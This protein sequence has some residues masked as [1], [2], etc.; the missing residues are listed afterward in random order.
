MTRGR[1]SIGVF[2]TD[3]ALVVQSWDSW[4]AEATGIPETAACGQP[5]AQLYPELARRGL[6][7]RLKRVADGMGVDVLAPAFHKYLLPCV[8]RDRMSRFERM[9]QHVTLAPLRNRDRVDGVVVTIED[10]TERFDRDRR[11]AADL[12]SH[13]EAIR[14]R[15]VKALAATGDAPALLSNALSDE[16]WRVRRVAAEGMADGGGRDVVQTLIEALREHHRDPALLNAALTALARTREDVVMA[17]VEL[18]A[19]DDAEVRTYAALALGLIDDARAAPALMDH[20][21]DTDQNVRFHVIEALGRLGYRGAADAISAIAEAGD[22]FLSFAALDALAAI[23]EPAVAPRLIPLLKD[24]S[25]R[26]A[27][28]ACLGALGA[29][30]VAIPLA[31]LIDDSRVNVGP[32]AVAIADVFARMEEEFGEGNLIADLARTALTPTSASVLT[33]AI[34]AAS[35]EELRALVVVLSWMPFDGIDATLADLL[36][37]GAV[38]NVVAERL[39][40]RGVLAAPFVEA[41]LINGDEDSK[42]AAAYA[43]GRLGSRSSAAKLVELLRPDEASSVI[44][45]VAGALGAIGDPL[46]FTRLLGMLDHP[47]AVVRQAVVAAL[48]SIGHPEM[49]LAI[50]ARLRDD[51]PRVREAAARVAGYFGYAS[52]LR[53]MVELCVDEEAIVRRSA[54]ESLVNYDQRPAWLKIYETI[55]SD[56]DATVRATAARALGRSTSEQAL[57]A[58]VSAAHDPNL[59]V[60]YY[61]LRSLGSRR[62]MHVGVLTTL[63]ERATLDDAAPVR[64]AAV[65][66]LGE[67]GAP[68]MLPVVIPLTRDSEPDIACAALA[69]LGFCAETAASAVLAEALGDDDPQRQRA[70]LH[71]FGRHGIQTGPEAVETIK[72]LAERTRDDEVRQHAIRTLGL[73][74]TPEAIDA[75]ISL[76]N[77]GR[78]RRMA[79]AALS[80]LGERQAFE[81]RSVL[82]SGDDAARGLV[83]DSLARMKHAAAA[84]MLI[85]A[86]DD[87]SAVIRLAAARAIGR[88][89]LHDARD[90]LVALATTDQNAAV[91]VAAGNALR[92]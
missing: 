26:P 6:L 29:E 49:E 22:F 63:A 65:E 54:V 50:A 88:L 8:P 32:I 55:S 12:D 81:L 9:R 30:D 44:I 47:E 72:Q 73:I 28:A 78:F 39:A 16:S 85:E 57:D 82:V 15:A 20:L 42:Q 52:C 74:G 53:Q 43:L 25:L 80:G 45:A 51:S 91:R 76:G 59:W 68:S 11:L 84:P 2:T 33:A 18:L 36:S 61:A 64:I 86:L 79:V 3:R 24:E 14:L 4:M 38:R 41:V 58:L 31:A 67:V 56:P 71:A 66:A 13:D 70:A 60:R 35:D 90:H 92:G 46:A 34:P 37:H 10:V 40:Q 89:D 5:I 19:L 1:R 23:G 69:T 21:D 62:S 77:D 17:I 75:L 48:N 27:A 83:V 7:A 87:P